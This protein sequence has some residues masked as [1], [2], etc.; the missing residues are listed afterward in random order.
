MRLPHSPKRSPTKR[1]QESSL[2]GMRV[3]EP[4]MHCIKSF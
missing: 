3:N 2:V 4:Q 1:M